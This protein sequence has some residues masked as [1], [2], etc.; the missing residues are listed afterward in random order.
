MGKL[1]A[2]SLARWKRLLT[3]ILLCVPAAGW[4]VVES[5][6]ESFVASATLIQGNGGTGARVNLFSL[7]MVPPSVSAGTV[8]A[9]AAG[10]VI[11]SNANWSA[12]Q[13]N[14]TNGLFYIEFDSGNR[15]DILA[16]DSITK[17]LSIPTGLTITVGNRYRIR[18]HLTIGAVFGN[19]NQAGLT[20]GAN[21][22][23]ADNVLVHNAQTQQTLT[24]FYSN[25]PGF[26]GWYS[27]TYTPASGTVIYPENGLMVRR[28]STPNLVLYL[29]G[30][31]KPGLAV[32]PVFSGFN[33]LGTL[34]SQ[35]ALKLSE[36][37]LYT[38]NPVTG[39]ASGSNPTVADNL[40]LVHP[41]TTTSSYFYSD[42]PGFEGWYD[43]AFQ[44]AADTL[45]DA[46]SA[47]FLQRK[48]PRGSFYWTIPA[49]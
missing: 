18:K 27:E 8:T 33:L 39:I 35:R 14:G 24:F 13:F 20:P 9:T 10:A 4:A 6:T 2:M 38:G 30:A 26:I 40:I 41:D 36:L 21:V 19:T 22:S 29:Q 1:Y 43:G 48:A 28:K 31:T 3:V 45:V 46:G 37:N 47:F 17:T 32:T 23:Q 12:N 15:A 34:K 25:V 44:P 5:A 42:Y 7:Q 49:E 11:D 16:T